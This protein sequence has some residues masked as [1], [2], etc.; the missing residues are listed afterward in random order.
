MAATARTFRWSTLLYGGLAA[1]LAACGGNPPPAPDPNVAEIGYG[2]R[3]TRDMTGAVGSVSSRRM[4]NLRFARVEEMMQGR[5]AGVTVTRNGSGG[6]AVRVRGAG[7]FQHDGEPLFVLDG[8]PINSSRPGHALDGI[9]PADVE[10]IDVLKDAGSAAIYGTRGAN[11][12]IL[13][14]TRRQ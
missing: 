13:I 11:G 8:V 1:L 4:G 10:R 3:H 5:I 14:T 2:T 6:Y 9:N 7:G 12:V